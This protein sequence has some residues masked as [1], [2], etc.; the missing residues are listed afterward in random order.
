MGD[1]AL[2]H[3]IPTALKYQNKLIQNVKGL[4][5]IGLGEAYSG[6]T[7][8]MIKKISNHVTTIKTTVDE[9]IERR[10]K[11]NKIEDM[12][13]RAM[14]YCDEISTL[15]QTIRYSVD[16]LELMVDDE[17]WPLVKYREMLFSR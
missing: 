17:D 5:E 4:K 2:N 9:M 16:K 14:M 10:K 11:A 7:I 8:D 6:T 13:E 1:L 12:R 15:F 3:V